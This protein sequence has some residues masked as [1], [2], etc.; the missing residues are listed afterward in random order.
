MLGIPYIVT[1]QKGDEAGI[2]QLIAAYT[3]AAIDVKDTKDDHT[4]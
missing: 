1:H 4:A 3:K 2:K